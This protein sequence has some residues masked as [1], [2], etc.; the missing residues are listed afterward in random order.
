MDALSTSARVLRIVVPDVLDYLSVVSPNIADIK[1]NRS[2]ASYGALSACAL[3]CSDWLRPAQMALFATVVLST[4][5]ELLID[6]ALPEV[7]GLELLLR[8]LESRPDLCAVVRSLQIACSADLLDQIRRILDLCGNVRVLTLRFGFHDVTSTV[9]LSQLGTRPSIR[10]FRSTINGNLFDLNVVTTIFPSLR[11]LQQTGLFEARCVSP[12]LPASNSLRLRHIDIVQYDQMW[13]DYL[14][15]VCDDPG[16]QILRCLQVNEAEEFLVFK[17]SLRELYIST[18]DLPSQVLDRLAECT[19]LRRLALHT[20][21]NFP[22]CLPPKLEVLDVGLEF[23]IRCD[24]SD[25]QS[26]LHSAPEMR[27]LILHYPEDVDLTTRMWITGNKMQ[28]DELRKVLA[29]S[30][31]ALRMMVETSDRASHWAYFA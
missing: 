15:R 18:T 30:G 11:S 20:A 7:K 22:H 6:S 4:C 24:L 28:P 23:L 3:V 16:I 10:A 13:L 12:H 19:Y 29:K 1:F 9:L 5:T 14:A 2:L 27:Q 31:V 21:L 25:V 17:R 26:L 8:T